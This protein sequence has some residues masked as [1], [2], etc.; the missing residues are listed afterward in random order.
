M[1]TKTR[2]KENTRLAALTRVLRA[3]ILSGAYPPGHRLPTHRELEREHRAGRKTVEGALAV[4]ARDGFVVAN[5]R[6]GTYV[7][8]APP[9]AARYGLVFPLA[10]GASGWTHFHTALQRAADRY[11][12]EANRHVVC[13]HGG[14]SPD[15]RRYGELLDDVRAHRLAGVI[16][17]PTTDMF[18]GTPLAGRSRLPKLMIGGSGPARHIL[19][20]DY[21]SF[22]RQAA[23]SLAK[24]GR[25]RVAILALGSHPDWV[26][27]LAQPAFKA[28]GL[29][30]AAR[31]VQSVSAGWIFNTLSLLFSGARSGRPDGLIVLDD[32]LVPETAM[33]LKALDL[34]VP[35]DLAVVAHANFPWP[36]TC[37]LPFIRIGFELGALLRTSLDRLDAL[38]RGDTVSVITPVPAVHGPARPGRRHE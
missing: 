31:W 18:D 37:P 9:H 16:F 24:A 10:P 36:T 34:R 29:A 1:S 2:P 15:A 23:A 35:R 25:R 28:Q 20:F 6:A 5:G 8:D 19:E 26:A 3:G 30:Y 21:A 11:R 17:T 4:L 14:V 22:M 12:D 7:V 27:K 13:Y 32:H 33:A 38:R